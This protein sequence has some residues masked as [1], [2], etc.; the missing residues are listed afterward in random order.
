MTSD[1]SASWRTD[2]V[3]ERLGELRKWY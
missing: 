3:K 1:N 2:D